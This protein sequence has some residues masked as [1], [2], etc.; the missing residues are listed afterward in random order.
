MPRPPTV[1]SV[2]G[3]FADF[4][5]LVWGLLYWNT[6]KSWFQL[7]R[8]RSRCPCQS[9]SDSGRALETHCEASMEWDKARR[10]RRVC[11]LLVETPQGWRCSVDTTQVR[12]FWGRA[13]GYYGGTLAALYLTGALG[14]FIF[15]RSVGYP[16]S[17][18]HVTWP[19]SWHRVGES[20]GWF[21]F[22][23]ARQ[24]FAAHRTGEALLYLAN[25]YEFD[26]GNYIAGLTL[27]KTLQSGQPVQSNRIYE[28]LYREHLSQREGTAEEWFRALLAR[29]DFPAIQELARDRLLDDSPHPSVWLRAL[30]FATRQTG[31]VELLRTL[32]A[33]PHP[34]AQAWR[35][36]LDAELLLLA[37]RPAEARPL[38]TRADW[39]RLPP[40]GTYYQV[41]ELIALGEV[42]AAMDRLG[43]AANLDGETR[44]ALQLT[45]YTHQ[46]ARR[47]FQQ[48]IDLLLAP[49]LTLPVIKILTVQLIRQPDSALLDRLYTKLTREP[50]LFTTESAGVYFS[51]L[52]AAGVQGDWTKFAALGQII[53]AGSHMSAPYF[54]TL[55]SFFRG[56]TTSDRITSIL[57]ML[58][59]PI[60]VNYALL[61]RYPGKRPASPARRDRP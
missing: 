42:F 51:F 1:N 3:W 47:P 38:L 22:E 32:R 53:T 56:R 9:P 14:V 37:G 26:P 18:I 11:P 6:R 2:T 52:C 19:P 60:E 5:R 21:F 45:A 44:L 61:E 12:P 36:L 30:I 29:G 40:Y 58:P 7:R 41:S 34:A 4:F 33:S 27:A 48:Q 31:R 59:L 20:R 16:V 15:L 10:F 43:A 50:I 24:A 54:L 55:E 17:L 46:G 23:K 57:P 28:R 13:A 49:K 39:S 25:S 35:P 8:G